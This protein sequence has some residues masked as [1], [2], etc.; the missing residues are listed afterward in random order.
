VTTEGK[1]LSLRTLVAFSNSSRSTTTTVSNPRHV[2]KAC[3]ERS[4]GY[5]CTLWVS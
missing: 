3:S 1:L 2:A 4:I 5:P